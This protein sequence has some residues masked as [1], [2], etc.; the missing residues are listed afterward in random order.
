MAAQK[1]RK[2]SNSRSSA[3]RGGG[4]R[5][6]RSSSQ[7]PEKYRFAQNVDGKDTIAEEIYRSYVADARKSK[8]SD[9]DVLIDIPVVK[10]DSI[11][12]ELENLTAHVALKAKVLELVKLNVGVSAEL[13][14][15][16]LD[17]K[18]V[19]A[20]A[21]LK[22][23]LDH[24]TA[25]VDRVLTTVDRNPEL[26]D[27]IGRAVEDVGG[28]TGHTLGE[29]GEAVE[30]VGEGT[31]EALRH[32]GGGAGQAVEGVGAGAGQAT[33]D[34]DQL[35]ANAGQ[36]VG[37]AGQ[38][39]GQAAGALGQGG[40]GSE[41]GGLGDV[42][43]LLSPEHS[44]RAKEAAKLTVKE[45]GATAKEKVK[46]IGERRRHRKAEE[47]DA[48]PRAYEVAEEREVD[49]DDVKGTGADGRITVRDV[50]KAASEQ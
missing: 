36:A 27:S 4:S 6:G 50:E 21:L 35:L 8:A 5:S 19:E 42:A 47:H 32:V 3:A 48:T 22:V 34:V 11:H 43:G 23:R 10:V 25:I 15:V 18:G 45:V 41:G 16:A 46:E 26:V 29:S 37:S 9:P 33:S 17:I 30:D 44:T 7:K 13:G 14:R 28:G 49:L 38:G 39:A 12:L 20:Q 31:E 24:V 40:G 1:T 2:R